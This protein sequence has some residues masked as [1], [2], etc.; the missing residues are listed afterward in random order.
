LSQIVPTW[1]RDLSF[2]STNRGFDIRRAIENLDPRQIFDEN[3][4][5][6]RVADAH[7]TY[8]QLIFCGHTGAT[9]EASFRSL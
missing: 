5:E 7:S 3:S 9:P 4:S 2:A 8:R 1:P 6:A